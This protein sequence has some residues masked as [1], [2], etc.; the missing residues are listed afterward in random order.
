MTRID[1]VVLL[2]AAAV[3]SLGA[4]SACKSELDNKPSA[5]VQPAPKEAP[6]EPGKTAEPAADPTKDVAKAATNAP[7]GG[8]EAVYFVDL[9]ASSIEFVG[10]KITGDH[11]GKFGKFEGFLG[12]QANKPLFVAF[13]VDVASLETDSPK[14]DTHLRSADFFDVEKHPKAAF[15]STSI[16]PSRDAGG[17][18]AITG[19]LEIRGTKQTI[20]FPATVTGTSGKAEF[21]I[22]RKDFGVA[23]PGKPD[24]L[25]KDEVL[26]KINLVFKPRPTDPAEPPPQ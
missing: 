20:T 13:R 15:T 7:P 8:N 3:V 9:S 2:T 5:V 24:D 17:T 23:F 22:N 14:L 21:K 25:I 16:R 11:T 12:L 19:E 1:T 6:V 10:A 18:H 4:T 26:L